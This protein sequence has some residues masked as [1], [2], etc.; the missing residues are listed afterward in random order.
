MERWNII[1]VGGG[2]AGLV[3]A[4][5]AAEAGATVLVCEKM[6]KVARKV[7]I[8]G[9]GRGNVTNDKPPELFA[10]GY[11][12]GGDFLR[13][14]FARFFVADT[15]ALLEKRGVPCV[16]ERGGRVFPASGKAQDV[17]K[18]LYR[19]ARAHGA[20][21]RTDAP[22]AEIAHED[23][24]FSLRIGRQRLGARHVI[25]ATGGKSYPATGSTGDGHRFAQALG[26]TIVE[27]RPAL[28]PLKLTGL[29]PELRVHLK[30]VGVALLDDKTQIAAGFGE[31]LLEKGEAGGPVPLNLARDVAGCKKPVLALDLKPALDEAKLDARLRRDLEAD[32]KAPLADVLRGLLPQVLLPLIVARAELNPE[33]RCAE[34]SKKT[35]L[36]LLRTLKRLTFPVADIGD[37]PQALVTAGGVRLDEVDPRTME[38]RLVPGLFFCGEVLD[39]D[40]VSGGYNLQAAF[41]TGYLAGRAAA[42]ALT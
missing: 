31:A 36:R 13:S 30:N 25:L 3:A 33:Q 11:R 9:K 18:A 24:G 23:D 21:V 12:H 39:I 16:T 26:H 1:I 22:I 42:K 34:I 4:G 15:I 28:A 7:G 6:S 40:G 38:S 14:A 2:A 27:P 17:V 35:R 8:S 20:A 5:A 29:P 19:Y 37:W 41:S 10:E 32:G